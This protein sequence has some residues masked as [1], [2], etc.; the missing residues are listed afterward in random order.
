MG[1]YFSANMKQYFGT[2]SGA[3]SVVTK[4]EFNKSQITFV[5]PEK[6]IAESFF[7]DRL[8][9]HHGSIE[10]IKAAGYDPEVQFR[11][12]P[13]GEIISLTVSYKTG[14]PNELRFYLRQAFKPLAGE[15][16]GLFVK[17]NEIWICHFSEWM[18]CEIESGRFL[19]QSRSEIL[20]PDDDDF[21]LLANGSPP[22]Q[23]Q[24]VVMKW[25]RDPSVASRAL[26]HA[27]YSCELFPKYPT[28]ISRNSNKPFLEAHHLIP[29]REQ[30]SFEVN[31][32]TPQNIC[33]LSPF[34]HRKIHHAAFDVILP[35]LKQLITK[36]AEL[37]EQ[38]SLIVDDV[39]GLYR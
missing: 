32:D 33:V 16:W 5:G 1:E 13:D 12:F 31:L 21:Q 37:L 38:L 25:K 29:M 36:R 17:N 23:V 28:F 34:A 6:K 2:L 35:D 24:S 18:R 30:K 26:A 19:V 8:E 3:F 15:F 22:G 11:K 10:A 27:S 39:L 9:N 7:G 20:E 4:D 14:K